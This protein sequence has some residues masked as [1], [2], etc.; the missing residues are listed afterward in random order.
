MRGYG[1]HVPICRE[2][3]FVGRNE[4][5]KRKEEKMTR[6]ANLALRLVEHTTFRGVGAHAEPEMARSEA[7]HSTSEVDAFTSYDYTAYAQERRKT[8]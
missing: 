4:A 6:R 3:L 5:A 8:V 1:R 7:H 2:R